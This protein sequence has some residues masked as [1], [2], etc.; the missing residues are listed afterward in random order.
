MKIFTPESA[1]KVC[2]SSAND[3]SGRDRAADG[4]LDANSLR[5]TE[6][7]YNSAPLVERCWSNAGGL[8]NSTR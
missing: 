7:Y 1:D 6:I 5:F 4:R 3:G 8:T 2:W